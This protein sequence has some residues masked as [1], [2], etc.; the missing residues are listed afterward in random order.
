MIDTNASRI[1]LQTPYNIFHPIGVYDPTTRNI[2]LDGF[3]ASS[4]ANKNGGTSKS[5]VPPFF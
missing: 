3:M 5:Q 1:A 2:I 4:Q